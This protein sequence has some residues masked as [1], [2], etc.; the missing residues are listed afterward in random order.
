MLLI[1]TKMMICP[2]CFEVYATSMTQ[3]C[4]RDGRRVLDSSSE[5]GQLLVKKIVQKGGI[6][7]NEYA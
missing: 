7:E 2:K 4:G 6:I 1:R 5:R 3:Y